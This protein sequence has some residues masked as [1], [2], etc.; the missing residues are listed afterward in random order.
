MY[1][2]TKCTYIIYTCIHTHTHTHTHTSK[3]THTHTN[4]FTHTF[5]QGFT[6]P[7]VVNHALIEH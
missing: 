6:Y 1:I 3:Y 4:I 5:M 2:Y 7:P